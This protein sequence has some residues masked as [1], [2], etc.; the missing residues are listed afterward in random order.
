MEKEIVKKDDALT[1]LA[2]KFSVNPVK[3]KDTIIKTCIK[4]IKLPNGSYRQATDE[5]FMALTIVS[6]KYDLNPMLGEIYAFP[7]KGGGVKPIVPIDGWVNLVNRQKDLDGVELTENREEGKIIS[8][9][10][11][12]YHKGRSIPTT[13]TEYMS[14]CKR[15]TDPW[16]KWEIRM[17]RH[18]AYI[19]CARI[20]YGFS[21]I[22]EPD[23][24]ERIIEIENKGN[25]DK[26]AIREPEALEEAKPEPK[27]LPTDVKPDKGKPPVVE[28]E[29]AKPKK[30][31]ESPKET[32]EKPLSYTHRFIACKKAMGSEDYFCALK[33]A[34]YESAGKIPKDKIDE[35]LKNL[36]EIALISETFKDEKN[37][38]KI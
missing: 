34:G 5:E 35:I 30:E 22:Y 4:N 32:Q 37:E 36:E 27:S 9:T 11:K 7:A 21:G 15:N 10:C 25:N 1:Q 18:K 33:N 14:E 38:P 12:L 23:E 6:N 28:P 26:P 29:V 2:A 3:L 13:V 8:V 17:L 31:P 20:A 19:Q 16:N 24:G